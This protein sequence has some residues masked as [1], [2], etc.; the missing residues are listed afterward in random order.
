MSDDNEDLF[1]ELWKRAGDNQ[2]LQDCL[3]A[4]EKLCIDLGL[5]PHDTETLVHNREVY[6]AMGVEEMEYIF[7]MAPIASFCLASR[8]VKRNSMSKEERNNLISAMAD[9]FTIGYVTGKAAESRSLSE[10]N[11]LFD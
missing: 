10:L 2:V 1:N 7:A 3:A 4:C 11:D 8:G 6:K 5:D 9:F